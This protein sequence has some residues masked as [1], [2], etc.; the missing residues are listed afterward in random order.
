MERED[1]E[2]EE[3]EAELNKGAQWGLAYG[4][5]MS[6]LMVFFLVLFAFSL[7]K[8]SDGEA[9]MDQGLSG[10]QTHF[11]GRASE[12]AQ[13]SERLRAAE[14]ATRR[15]LERVVERQGLR[16]AVRVEAERRRLRLVLAAPVLF[17]SGSADVKEESARLLFELAATLKTDDG[18]EVRVEGHTD[19]V[20]VAGG[21]FESNWELSSA[22]ANAVVA[23][24]MRW[25]LDPRRLAAAGF[26]EFRPRVPNDGPEHRAQNRRIEI[27][28]ARPEG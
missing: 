26:G 20:P 18:R 10:L 16:D 8:R 21:E 23:L 13:R 5:F 15:E 3:L 12:E 1:R 19:D 9:P 6:Y 24:L 25:G 28:L 2:F 7:Q 27:T 4:D 11:G 22:R 14:D 17:D